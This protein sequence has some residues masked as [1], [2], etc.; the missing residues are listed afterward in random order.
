MLIVKFYDQVN[1]RVLV[2]K[3]LLLGAAALLLIANLSIV[4]F[5]QDSYVLET[6]IINNH[7]DSF[8]QLAHSE[9]DY[10]DSP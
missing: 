1:Q 3:T 4:I 2:L 8:N 10:I 9:T 6:E 5:R 7:N